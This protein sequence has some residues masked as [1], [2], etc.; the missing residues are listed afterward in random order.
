[1]EKSSECEKRGACLRGRWRPKW[2]QTGKVSYRRKD[3]HS[4]EPRRSPYKTEV[5]G[6]TWVCAMISMKAELSKEEDLTSTLLPFV[7]KRTIPTEDYF[8]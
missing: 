4:K 3:K 7:R 6:W 2:E 8:T 1:M 5:A